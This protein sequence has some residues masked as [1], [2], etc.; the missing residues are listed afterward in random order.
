M[1]FSESVFSSGFIQKTAKEDLI[2][3]ENCGILQRHQHGKDLEDT[4]RHHTAIEGERLL[5][6]TGDPTYRPA[7]LWVPLLA[8]AF[9]RR[10]ST[11][12]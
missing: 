11:A 3:K 2:V 8:S 9:L 7:S 1:S 12:S 6:G 4:R 10:F 5:V